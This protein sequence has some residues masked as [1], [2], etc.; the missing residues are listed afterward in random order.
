MAD[1]R[2]GKCKECTKSDATQHRSKNLD[3]IKEYDRLRGQDPKRK[4]RNL[5]N[6]YKRISSPE[7]R[8]RE[9]ERSA[10]WR[11]ENKLKRA[12]HIMVGNALKSGRLLRTSC[13]KCGSKNSEAHH[14]D[15]LK[16]LDVNWLCKECHGARH[17]ELNELRRTEN[18]T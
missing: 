4:K 5:I 15:Y 11:E 8:R 2:L 6:Y 16:P 17:R 14:E 18:A 1:G 3:R 10:Q 12:A 7:G 9:W 13:E